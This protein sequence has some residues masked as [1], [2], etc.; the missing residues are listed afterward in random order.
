MC[1]VNN[2]IKKKKKKISGEYKIKNMLIKCEI[3]QPGESKNIDLVCKCPQHTLKTCQLSWKLLQTSN[4]K[5]S[6]GNFYTDLA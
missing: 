2:V 3:I 4:I 6:I 5:F 1:G